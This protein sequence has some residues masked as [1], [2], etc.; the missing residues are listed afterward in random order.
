[1]LLEI[2]NQIY[3]LFNK[4]YPIDRLNQDI[5]EFICMEVNN[6][7]RCMCWEHYARDPEAVDEFFEDINHTLKCYDKLLNDKIKENEKLKKQHNIYYITTFLIW[8]LVWYL[9][10]QLYNFL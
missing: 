2:D 1:M 6:R 9:L 5:E 10:T 7:I 8:L 3:L 4:M